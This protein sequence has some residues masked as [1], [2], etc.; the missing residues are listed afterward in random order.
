MGLK[1]EI[2]KV[3]GVRRFVMVFPRA[4]AAFRYYR[5]PLF[6]LARWVF[7]SREVTNY[8]YD[9]TDDN[10]RYLAAMLAEATG[11]GQ[12]EIEAYF[13]EI[14]TDDELRA[15]VARVLGRK[16][17]AAAFADP[18]VRLGRRVGW[19]ALVRA[20]KPRVVIETGVDKG[21]GSCVLAAA[22]RRNAAEGRPGRYY[23]TDINPSAG[24]LLAGPYAEHG[25]ILYGDSITS[26]NA[27]AEPVDVFINDSD[28]SADYE[29]DEY[30]TILPKLAPGAFIIGDNAH[31]TDRL[32]EFS[33][34]EGRSFLF[35]QE[36]PK[37]H[38]YPGAGIGL[39]FHRGVASVS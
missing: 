12:A 10:K 8:T 1:K 33:L 30:R 16:R 28:H 23:G 24:Y 4:W 17:D 29:A 2:L 37:D 25:R 20:T 26:L 27:F 21:L 5:R 3:P 19:Y 36:K 38:W 39:S 15:H 6:D 13:R 31:V 22:L 9:L 18:V 14:E 32:L 7:R 11:C 35:F 34:R